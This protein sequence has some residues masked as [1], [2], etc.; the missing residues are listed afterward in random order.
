MDEVRRDVEV[1][2]S[3]ERVW[4]LITEPE[5]I[6]AWYAFD[7]AAIDLRAGGAVEHYWEEHG[8]YLGTIDV[9]ERPH[10]FGYLYANFPDEMPVE[11]RSTHVLFELSALDP[12][13]TR[14][15][16]TESGLSALDLTD[17]ERA[18]YREATIQGWEGGL[19]AL[20]HH[21][22]AGEPDYGDVRSRMSP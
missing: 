9:L 15:T 1:R 8:R 19:P 3:I 4:A 20:A 5:H 6:K 13:R 7:G 18:A 17:D 11:G 12:S 21:A 14:V 22:R 10:R 2:A 16:V